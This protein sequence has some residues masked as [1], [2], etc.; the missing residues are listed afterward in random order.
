[1]AGQP[2]PGVSNGLI[3]LILL[4]AGGFTFPA[5]TPPLNANHITSL[6]LRTNLVPR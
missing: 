4:S 2:V 3:G 6:E 1:M 5:G